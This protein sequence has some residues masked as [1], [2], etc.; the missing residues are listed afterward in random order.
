VPQRALV[1]PYLERFFS[2]SCDSMR[3]PSPL[4]PLPRWGGEGNRGRL[5]FHTSLVTGGEVA[6]TLVCS[7][8]KQ[9][10]QTEV[11]ATPIGSQRTTTPHNHMDPCQ[12]SLSR[13]PIAMCA[14]GQTSPSK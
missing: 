14:V 11:C 8:S 10:E 4:A 5:I 13:F 2:L 1:F 3:P 7:A 9:E 6:Q 12:G